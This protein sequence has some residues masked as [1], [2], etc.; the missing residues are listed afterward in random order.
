MHKS[1]LT[2]A[3]SVYSLLTVCSGTIAGL[4]RTYHVARHRR[5]FLIGKIDKL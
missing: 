1:A 4:A 5:K 2:F 3:Q